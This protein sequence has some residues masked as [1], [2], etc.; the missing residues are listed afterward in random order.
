M[1]K[2]YEDWRTRCLISIIGVIASV[3]CALVSIIDLIRNIV[4]DTKKNSSHP[5]QG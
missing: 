1:R 4:N 3:I 2:D 5:D